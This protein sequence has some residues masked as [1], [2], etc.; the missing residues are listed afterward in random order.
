MKF[1][2]NNYDE[3]FGAIDKFKDSLFESSK[4]IQDALKVFRLTFPPE[5]GIA[6]KN[7]SI[8]ENISNQCIKMNLIFPFNMTNE[9]LRCISNLLENPEMFEARILNYYSDKDNQKYLLEEV[10]GS[11]IL[12]DKYSMLLQSIDAFNL[13]LFF[14]S[15][16][17][18]GAIFEGALANFTSQK[19]K[20]GDA[21]KEAI[22]LNVGHLSPGLYAIHYFTWKTLIEF[23]MRYFQF[24]NFDEFQPL[25]P[26][27]HWM[28]HGRIIRSV[29]SD[30]C[31][32]LFMAILALDKLAR[33]ASE[34][35]NK[36][37]E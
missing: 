25:Y 37:D 14:P 35:Q 17:S 12:A 30:D 27:R 10:Q 34:H 8:Y 1:N 18:L 20:K 24:S 26:N 9:N 13:I 29:S 23:I 6:L 5:L 33:L 31:T 11:Q 22:N 28:M 2:D 4:I 3:I 36:L 21:F 19:I 15:A 16:I 32:R 7:A